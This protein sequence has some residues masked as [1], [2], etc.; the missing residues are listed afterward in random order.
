ME[1]LWLFFNWVAGFKGFKHDQF[2]Y[3]TMLDI[4]GEAGKVSSMTHVFKQ[5]QEKGIKIDDITYTSLMH[6]LSNAGDVDEV[7]Q[8]WEE[9]RAQGCWSSIFRIRRKP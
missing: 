6:W 4:F 9:M 1:K 8:I 7:V 2:T 5:M 3:T